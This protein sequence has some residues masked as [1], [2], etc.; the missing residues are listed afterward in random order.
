M[1][2]GALEYSAK[3]IIHLGLI[4]ILFCI[5]RPL[6][7]TVF[8]IQRFLYYKL[9]EMGQIKVDSADPR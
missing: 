3:F 2:D 5:F 1:I 8:P 9:S 6:N 4:H 7:T